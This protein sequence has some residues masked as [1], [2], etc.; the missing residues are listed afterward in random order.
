MLPQGVRLQPDEMLSSWLKTI[1]D[2]NMFDR[3]SLLRMMT[4]KAERLR[5]HGRSYP[6]G[7]EALYDGIQKSG[8]TEAE[9]QDLIRDNTLFFIE[10]PF[11]KAGEQ[12]QILEIIL[13]WKGIRALT[14]RPLLTDKIQK[15]C[16]VC[17]REDRERCGRAYIHVPHQVPGVEACYRHGCRLV[18]DDAYFPGQEP[19]KADE[20]EVK[21]AQFYYDLYVDPVCI[22]DRIRSIAVNKALEEK[23]LT[24]ESFFEKNGEVVKKSASAKSWFALTSES[25]HRFLAAVFEYDADMFRKTAGDLADTDEEADILKEISEGYD[26]LSP[27]GPVMFLGCRTCGA[28]FYTHPE[29]VR[30]GAGCPVCDR[31]LTDEEVVERY[32]SH[33]GDGDYEVTGKGSAVK[34]V[35]RPCGTVVKSP[36]PVFVF[37]NGDCP[38]CAGKDRVGKVRTN[39]DGKTMKIVSYNSASDISVEFDDGTVVP[40]RTYQQFLRGAIEN[41]ND[42]YRTRRVGLEN[43]SV[44][45]ERMK[46]IAYRGSKNVDVMLEDGTVL[47]D[48]W[49]DRFL[50][51]VTIPP[52]RRRSALDYSPENRIGETSR[53]NSGQMMTIIRYRDAKDMDVMFEDGTEACGIAYSHFKEG[54]V[55]NPSLR[56]KREKAMAAAKIKLEKDQKEKKLK[57]QAVRTPVVK[58]PVDHTGEKATALNGQVME[59]IAYRCRTDVD[60]RF[61]D[62]TVVTGKNY[63]RFRRGLISNPNFIINRH[64]KEREGEKRVNRY[65]EEMEITRYGS[66]T[67]ID[68]RFCSGAVVKRRSYADFLKDNIKDPDRERRE[69][70]KKWLGQVNVARNG[71]NMKVIACRKYD[72]ADIRFEDGTVIEHISLKHF[73]DRSIRHPGL[74]HPRFNSRVGETA[75]AACGQMM[76]IIAYR[77]AGDIDIRFED[78]TI[79]ENRAYAKFREGNIGHPGLPRRRKEPAP[80]TDR[81]GETG[82]A[83]DGST[84]KIVAFRGYDD[85]DVEFA[86]GAVSRHR[87]YTQFTRGE[88]RNPN[89]PHGLSKRQSRVGEVR[90]MKNGLSATIIAY[91]NNKDVT[92]RFENGVVRERMCYSNF[93]KGDISDR[94]TDD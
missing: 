1:K 38:V 63:D 26:L 47:R 41:P 7:L 37:R 64:K 4:G 52:E 14:D 22:D 86:D 17:A 81:T 19:E 46:I 50:A 55:R 44:T 53:A 29:L 34:I 91:R 70:E 2:I 57:A 49:F 72:D 45:G 35:H 71:M 88:I 83:S 39:N 92:V 79:V 11:M 80:I 21:I 15:I 16:P 9:I 61:E 3:D 56:E 28:E 48:Q 33:H 76:T 43:V 67:D 87:Q 74:E 77:G 89:A 84:I 32:A 73:E 66:Y 82:T 6:S 20:T 30:L 40:H 58:T 8:M 93:V 65:G 69:L 85:I 31:S 94:T 10:L 36:L 60:V 62:G 13:R 24:F 25:Q 27:Y 23:G 42:N 59:L 5:L 90:V 54:R 68:V 12:A 18:P 75:M 78:G 51:G